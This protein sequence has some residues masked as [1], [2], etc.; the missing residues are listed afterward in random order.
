MRD[1][2][3]GGDRQFRQFQKTCHSRKLNQKNANRKCLLCQQQRKNKTNRSYFALS[4]AVKQQISLPDMITAQKLTNFHQHQV[5]IFYGVNK[6][7]YLFGVKH[8]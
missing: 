5:N 6:K 4:A 2:T 1:M 7:K 8:T 3:G